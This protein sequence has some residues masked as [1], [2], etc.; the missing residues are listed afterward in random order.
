MS[1][2]RRLNPGSLAAMALACLMLFPGTV[3]AARKTRAEK[4]EKAEKAEK[5]VFI[6][7]DLT[8]PTFKTLTVGSC[9]SER[10]RKK[11]G[12]EEW[13]MSANGC[14]HA[15]LMYPYYKK[16]PWM[17]QLIAKSIILPMF[18]ERL[19]EKPARSNSGETL[20]KEKLISLVQKGGAYGSI[21][22]PPPID[23][24]A[25]LAGYEKSPLS[26]AGLPFPEIFG[27]YLQFSFTHELNQ[28]YDAH[29][30]GPQGGFIVIDV[31]SRR[32]LT[33]NDLILPGQEKS[34]ENLQR[35]AF[36]AWLRS[37][38]NL[39]GEAIKVHFTDPA[40]AFRLNRNWR[41]T[42]GGLM[43]RFATYEIGP[44]PFGSPEI[45]VEKERLRNIIQPDILE[46]IP[47]RELTAVN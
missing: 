38:R 21:E 46:Q 29:P 2:R 17:N 15:R 26:P 34:L 22:K 9:L 28:Q 19:D 24:T 39:P 47:D 3:D 7:E 31:Q 11:G 8:H 4:V 35:A 13:R 41:I 27:P 43:F 1:I 6:S 42:E 30:Q 20:Y 23:F 12:G 5:K 36:H 44:R 32:V 14:S 16:T 33:F 37:E 25:K 45:F 40:Y 18:A 10:I